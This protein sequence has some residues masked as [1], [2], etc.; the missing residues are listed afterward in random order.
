MKENEPG[1]ECGFRREIRSFASDRRG[2][3]KQF[4]SLERSLASKPGAW[5]DPSDCGRSGVDYRIG[6]PCSP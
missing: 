2:C 4:P 5:T 6:R 1:A 3:Q